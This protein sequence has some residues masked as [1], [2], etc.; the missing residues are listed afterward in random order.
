MLRAIVKDVCHLLELYFIS[1]LSYD[2]DL[3]VF[4][5]LL[6]DAVDKRGRI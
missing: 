4:F 2:L 1:I 6:F 5:V 3:L